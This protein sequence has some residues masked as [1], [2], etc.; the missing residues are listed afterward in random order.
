MHCVIVIQ[1]SMFKYKLYFLKNKLDCV[2]DK[3]TF[4]NYF[5]H[6]WRKGDPEQRHVI[7][8]ENETEG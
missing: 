1:V 2:M 7:Q 5:Q 6:G 4:F 8:K 3:I